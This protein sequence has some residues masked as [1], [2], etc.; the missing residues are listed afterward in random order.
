MLWLAATDLYD[1]DDGA[2]VAHASTCDLDVWLQWEQVQRSHK[3]HAAWC[4]A[5]EQVKV[6]TGEGDDSSIEPLSRVECDE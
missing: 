3:Q 1:L 2:A 6:G 5:F 4:R